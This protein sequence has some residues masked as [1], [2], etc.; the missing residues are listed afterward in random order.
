MKTI[1]STAFAFIALA[2]V[3]GAESGL[4]KRELAKDVPCF[5]VADCKGHNL[6]S[7]EPLDNGVY[8]CHTNGKRDLAE[9][10]QDQT[11]TAD[12]ANCTGQNLC[13]CELLGNTGVYYCHTP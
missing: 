9:D 8:Y 6:C 5:G 12:V 4:R 3:Q 13:V 7:C 10:T 11:C 1:F 2:T